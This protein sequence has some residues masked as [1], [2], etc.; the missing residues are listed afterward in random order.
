VSR[1]WRPH[2]ESALCLNFRKLLAD[3]LLKVGQKTS[4]TLDWSIKG[5]PWPF[6][7]AGFAADLEEYSGELTLNY[8]V[9]HEGN[10][11]A[12]QVQCRINLSS[13]PLHFGGR[14]WYMHCPLTHRRAVKLYKFARTDK[15]VSRVALNI[16]PTYSI[17]RCSGLDRI[18]ERRW[19]LR[20]RMGDDVSDL[21]GPPYR[22]RGMRHQVFDAYAARDR[23]LENEEE[24]I[25][26]RRFGISDLHSA[27]RREPCARANDFDASRTSVPAR[28]AL[29]KAKRALHRLVC[30]GRRRSDG[31][32]CQALSVPGKQRCKWHGG[33]STG[34]KSKEGKA[35]A[36]ANLPW[37]R[38]RRT[39]E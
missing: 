24:A 17:Q 18:I 36:A 15:F 30:G 14:R 20:E 26:R 35:R 9:K 25:A 13:I 8:T 2:I 5:E 28:I 34:P 38:A 21:F 22:P 33:C 16:A 1:T 27:F 6:A 19:A 10:N 12:K 37:A 29:R 23:K 31:K 3:G 39:D 32:P 4:G 11:Q 7:S